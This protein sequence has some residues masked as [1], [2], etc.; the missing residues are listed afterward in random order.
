MTFFQV[1]DISVY[2]IP[3]V[4]VKLEKTPD[5]TLRQYFL[6]TVLKDRLL[7]E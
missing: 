6:N 5:C 3:A 2:T 7:I 4:L 1:A